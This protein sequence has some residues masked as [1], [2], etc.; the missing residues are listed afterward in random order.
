MARLVQINTAADVA[1]VAALDEAQKIYDNDKYA[2]WADWAP[3]LVPSV[4]DA[5]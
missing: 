1:L 4:A 2:D 3:M 5:K